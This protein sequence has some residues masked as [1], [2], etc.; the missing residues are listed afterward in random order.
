MLHGPKSDT[1]R[2]MMPS[3]LQIC[4]T[5]TFQQEP[6]QDLLGDASGWEAAQLR[7]KQPWTGGLWQLQGSDLNLLCCMRAGCSSALGA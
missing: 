5:I 7:E 1:G 4:C 6:V 2:H 3:W